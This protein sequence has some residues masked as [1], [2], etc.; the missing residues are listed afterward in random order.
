MFELIKNPRIG[1]EWSGHKCDR[2]EAETTAY[3]MIY[4]GGDGAV[5]LCQGCLR[6]AT[7]MIKAGIRSQYIND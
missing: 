5:K 2:C 4:I 7:E 1:Y 3:V 6:E